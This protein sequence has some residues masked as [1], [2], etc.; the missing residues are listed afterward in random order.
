M[1]R[2]MDLIRTLLFKTEALP[3]AGGHPISVEG[4]N[5]AEVCEHLR[6]AQEAGLIE[7]RFLRGDAA[8]CVALRL[9]WAGHEFL[10]AARENKIWEKAKEMAMRTAEGVTIISLKVALAHLM[11]RPSLP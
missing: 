9:T 7:A 8:S 5:Q 3:D 2:D 6:L 4:R 1:K 10:D 11:G